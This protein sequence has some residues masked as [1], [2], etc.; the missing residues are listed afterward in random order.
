MR[1]RPGGPSDAHR[2]RRHLE[3]RR[4]DFVALL[5]ANGAGKTTVLRAVSNLL[6]AVRGQ[7]R[8]DVARFDGADS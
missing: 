6:Q 1:R 8:A 4:Q 2:L 7:A 5:G 3:V